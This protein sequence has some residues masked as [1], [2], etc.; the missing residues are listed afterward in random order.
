MNLC[1]IGSFALR[2][3]MLDVWIMIIFGVIAFYMNRNGY[4]ILP[5]ILALILGKILEEVDLSKTTI[6]ISADHGSY[7]HNIKYG[8][9]EIDF[10][11]RV[12]F[13]LLQAAM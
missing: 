9:K 6:I 11:C 5:M 8:N 2:N 12:R 3:S 1:I 7:I 13:F 10:D 4:P